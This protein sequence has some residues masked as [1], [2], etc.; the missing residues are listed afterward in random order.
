[1][2]YRRLA[3]DELAELESE[4]IQ[5]LASNTITGPDWERLK[6]DRPQQ[7]EELIDLFSD[8]VFEKVLVQ[9]RFLEITTPKDIRTFSCG[10]E[11]IKMNGIRIVG[12]TNVDFSQTGDPQ[13][14]LAQ[15]QQSGAKLQAYSGEKSYQ[16][17]RSEELFKL[18]Q[19]GALISPDG[20]LFNTLEALKPPASPDPLVS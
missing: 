8:I 12:D 10:E 14:M 19:Q 9:V 18:M 5:F 15:A 13:T 4:F 2:K 20:Y 1:M 11:I 7:A 6:N 17:S 16:P 3:P